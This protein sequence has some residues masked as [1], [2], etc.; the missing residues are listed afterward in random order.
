MAPGELLRVGDRF[1]VLSD[2]SLTA[3]SAQTIAVRFQS[4]K[5]V[6]S[7]AVWNG[8]W[9]SDCLG[10]AN[11]QI[12]GTE[13]ESSDQLHDYCRS[14]LLFSDLPAETSLQL[15]AAPVLAGGLVCDFDSG[16]MITVFASAG[17]HHNAVCAG[18]PASYDECEEGRFVPLSPGTINVLVLVDAQLAPAALPRVFTIVAE[19][20]TDLLRERRVMSCYSS[21]IAT[22]TG[23]DSTI[24]VAD[25][26]ALR[27]FSTTSTHSRL[28]TVI[29]SATRMAIAKALDN[30]VS[31]SRIYGD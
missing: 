27:R 13:F 26:N 21:R 12:I 6:L 5:T 30:A 10:V 25:P 28:G 17:V 18:D 11:H 14:V 9:F 29:A 1:R 31:I 16:V 4:P 22:G 23:T 15:T 2:S 19:A 3:V 20:K 7:D 8:G 24:V